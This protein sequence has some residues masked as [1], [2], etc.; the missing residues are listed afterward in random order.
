M[1]LTLI[2]GYTKHGKD[3]FFSQLGQDNYNY[4]GDNVSIP[5]G[6]V[7]RVAFADSLK[8]EVLKLYNIDAIPENKDQIILG[9]LSFRDLCISR[10]KQVKKDNKYHYCLCIKEEVLSHLQKGHHVFITDWRFPEEYEYFASY[11]EE[12]AP[13]KI[14][15]LRVF[16]PGF[17]IPDKDVPSEHSLDGFKVDIVA[18][19]KE[20]DFV[21]GLS[22]YREL[23]AL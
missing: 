22:R 9:S 8:T 1:S 18:I 11:E 13:Y 12:F 7:H 6:L 14:R 3:T 20:H 5:T 10:S 2:A 4:L 17:P 15:T 23:F 21:D 19:R 16:R